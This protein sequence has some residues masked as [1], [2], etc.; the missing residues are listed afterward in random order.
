MKKFVGKNDDP[1][2][3]KAATATNITAQ[4]VT[5]TANEWKKRRK[6]VS[7]VRNVCEENRIHGKRT[8]F[9]SVKFHRI[10]YV[11]VE[12]Q[13]KTDIATNGKWLR[14]SRENWCARAGSDAVLRFTVAARLKIN[15]VK[16][17]GDSKNWRPYH[18]PVFH[19]ICE[20]DEF[21]AEHNLSVG[22]YV[23]HTQLL[24]SV[25]TRSAHTPN[26]VQLNAVER[27]NALNERLGWA[28]GT[29]N[30]NGKHRKAFNRRTSF[31]TFRR[32]NQS[33]RDET[34]QLIFTWIRF[35]LIVKWWN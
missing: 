14:K 11:S 9:F 19:W 21:P 5:H 13:Q 6:N 24:L 29:C 15:S 30:T 2:R 28:Q 25:A 23:E 26:R 33:I 7:Q 3:K 8:Y 12:M 16:W 27:L 31:W 20:R 1:H 10:A 17:C 32:G 22:V 34:V 18:F 35:K 4:F